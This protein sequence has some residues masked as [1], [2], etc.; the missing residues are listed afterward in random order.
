MAT[1]NSTHSKIANL[2]D[3][4]PLAHW[5][6]RLLIVIN[7]IKSFGLQQSLT[8]ITMAIGSLGLSATMFLG[9]GALDGLW[10][11][12]DRLMGNRVQAYADAGPGDILLKKRPNFYFTASDLKA[13]QEKLPNSRYV[14]PM[15]TGRGQIALKEARII[16]SVD[17]ITKELESEP[18]YMPVIGTSFSASARRGFELECLI[19][20]AS[21][22]KLNADINQK[23]SID[24]YSCTVV[25]IIPNPPE[26]DERFKSRVVIPYFWAQL[27]WGSPD[28]IG[29]IMVSWNSP[30]EMEQTVNTL[31]R[32]LDD[33]RARGAYHLSS[34]QFA[35]K[36]RKN[37]VSNFMVFGAIQSIFSIIVASIGIVNV[38]LANVVRRSKEFAVRIAMGAYTKDIAI[39]VISE[40]FLLGLLGAG[41]G[42]LLAIIMA[43]IV[44]H[45]ISAV[46]PE[47]SNLK[48]IIS[49]KGIFAPIIVCGISGLIAGIIPALRACKVD[50]LAVLRAE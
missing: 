28:N 5:Y 16:M 25:G 37:I 23:I 32:V 8:L 48:P 9:Q 45:Y 33:E 43:P 41:I 47:A 24:N 3:G 14:V 11:D 39:I 4:S 50:V 15:I 30:Q 12:L 46:I 49:I 35:I 20:V 44:S 34:S 26:A 31:R 36:K 22:Q 6:C 10:V 21:A 18:A 38:M 29:S 40:S 27:F 42:V 17:G 7:S 13:V 2:E 1:N 19:T